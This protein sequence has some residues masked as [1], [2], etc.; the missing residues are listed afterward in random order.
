MFIIIITCILSPYT[1]ASQTPGLRQLQI[2]PSTQL[3]LSQTPHLTYPS[4]YY[5]NELQP[6]SGNLITISGVDIVYKKGGG[7]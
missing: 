2:T 3:S 6:Q 7:A 5:E 4:K 1:F